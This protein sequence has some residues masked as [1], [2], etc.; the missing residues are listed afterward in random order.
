[1][2]GAGKTIV[3]LAN[4]SA[5]DVEFLRD[6]RRS[7]PFGPIV[8]P[9]FLAPWPREAVA[10]SF[11]VQITGEDRAS[12]TTQYTSPHFAIA[13]DLRLPVGVVRDLAAVLEAARAA[14]CAVP[15]GIQPG[16]EPEKYRVRLFAKADDYSAVG[17]NTGTGGTFTHGEMLILLPNLGI[18]ATTNGLSAEHQKSLFVIKHEVIHQLLDPWRRAFPTWFDEG[19]AETF[20]AVPYTRGRYTFQN[21]DGAMREYLLKW[22]SSRDSRALRLITPGK[23]MG[24]S[25]D[26]WNNQLSAQSAYEL[27]NSAGLLVYWL[28]YRD[29]RGDG[30]GVAAYFDAVRQGT[31]PEEAE[32]THL[33]RGRTPDQIA[34]ELKALSRRMALEVTME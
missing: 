23:L 21:L 6:W 3:P 7:N 18:Q 19:I 12:G 16:F 10:E 33:L 9:T 1:V 17:G 4:L 20:A 29:G 24:L 28:L 8:D 11:E 13:S 34:T 5:A 30:A 25:R 27:Y 31:R 26:D 14:V 22:R 32:R 2:K 15:L